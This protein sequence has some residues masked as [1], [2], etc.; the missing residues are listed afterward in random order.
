MSQIFD[1]YAHVTP[2]IIGIYT[3]VIGYHHVWEFWFYQTCIGVLTSGWF[4]YGQTMMA[5]VS[6]APKMYIFFALYNT[7][8]KTAAFVGPFITSAII[9]DAHGNTNQAFWFTLAT[10]LVGLV[11]IAMVDTDKAKL[12][13]AKYLESE[14]AE[15]Y[16]SHGSSEIAGA[17]SDVINMTMK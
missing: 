13:N 2:G 7:L 4:S 9:N 3:N 14:R 17:T 1:R 11:L 16:A 12:D 6:P 10:G 5:E 15:L 8:G